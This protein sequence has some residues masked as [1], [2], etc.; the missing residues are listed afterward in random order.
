MSRSVMARATTPGNDVYRDVAPTDTSSLEVV[1]DG[2]G[3]LATTVVTL[4]LAVS[5]SR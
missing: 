2:V 3:A 5:R 1:H 4:L